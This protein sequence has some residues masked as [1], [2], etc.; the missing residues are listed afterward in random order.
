MSPLVGVRQS[1]DHAVAPVGRG[2]ALDAEPERVVDIRGAPDPQSGRVG[3]VIGEVGDAE[4]LGP[5]AQDLVRD[6]PELQAG[7]PER[8]GDHCLLTCADEV[9]VARIGMLAVPAPREVHAGLDVLVD[10]RGDL[11]L[12]GL[13]SGHARL[14]RA[15]AA[16]GEE[17]DERRAGAL[18]LL[19]ADRAVVHLGPVRDRDHERTAPKHAQ[20]AGE[21]RVQ[22]PQPLQQPGI[23]GG[24]VVG[25]AARPRLTARRRLERR[26]AVAGRRPLGGGSVARS[27]NPSRMPSLSASVALWT[28]R[29]A[30]SCCARR[31]PAWLPEGASNRRLY[32][33]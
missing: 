22:R 33:M 12:G 2:A 28:Y 5:T 11:R 15:R 9:A 19:D 23:G 30:G 13:P 6:V 18:C 25:R 32:A 24:R 1:V 3:H 7:A 21:L 31:V 4:H 14:D 10:R 17:G 27:M 20:I 29:V 16:C 26:V 8:E